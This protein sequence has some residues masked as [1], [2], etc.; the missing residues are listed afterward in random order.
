MDGEWRR[1]TYKEIVTKVNKIENCV[2]Y[3]V[4]HFFH[5]TSL[6][7]LLL[8][9]L[10]KAQLIEIYTHNKPHQFT[11]KLHC[12][13]CLSLSL[14]LRRSKLFVVLKVVYYKITVFKTWIDPGLL[15]LPNLLVGW[16]CCLSPFQRIGCFYPNIFYA[17]FVSSS[18]HI[19]LS[20]E[21]MC[22]CRLSQQ[23][24]YKM[25]YPECIVFS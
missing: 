7:T 20:S 16:I 13:Y 24:G 21:C 8:Y 2:L 14:V 19:V 4:K 11:S 12:T 18:S 5:T 1:H 23:L 10:H 6:P 9:W 25:Y 15:R 3:K 17:L 22:A